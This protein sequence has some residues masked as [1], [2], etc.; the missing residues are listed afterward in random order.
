MDT[1]KQRAL[2]EERTVSQAKTKAIPVLTNEAGHQHH[3][4]EMEFCTYIEPTAFADLKSEKLVL[5]PKNGKAKPNVEWLGGDLF[6]ITA[7]ES[8][9]AQPMAL[10][11]VVLLKTDTW[12]F[13]T[14]ADV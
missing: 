8:C 2:G 5:R 11:L 7:E 3:A 13:V 4:K 9:S 6:K 14:C 1:V 10:P 12:F